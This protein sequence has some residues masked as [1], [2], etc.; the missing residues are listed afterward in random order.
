MALLSV[1]F[2]GI[3][4]F[5]VVGT[6][7]A[8]LVCLSA[9]TEPLSR[10]KGFWWACGICVVGFILRMW[11]EP[12]RF[13]VYCDEFDYVNVAGNI[14]LK[15]HL[16]T[17]VKG[18]F[19]APEVV[20]HAHRPG[21]Y[22]FLLAVLYTMGLDRISAGFLL[23]T[24]LGTASI[25]LI[26][27]VAWLFFRDHAVAAWSAASLAF[28]PVHIQYSTD[29]HTNVPAIFFLLLS[30]FFLAEYHDRGRKVLLW[31]GLL[32]GCFSAYIRPECGLFLVVGLVIWLGPLSVGN[33]ALQRQRFDIIFFVG[34][35]LLPL[36]VQLPQAITFESES[37]GR[38]FVSVHFFLLHVGSN[39]RYLFLSSN[40]GILTGVLFLTGAVIG[41]RRKEPAV[42]WLLLWAVAGFILASSYFAGSFF[43]HSLERHILLF[44]PPFVWLA[45]LGMGWLCG[46]AGRG[47]VYLSGVFVFFLVLSVAGRVV[48]H[49][50]WTDMKHRAEIRGV[51]FSDDIVLMKKVGPLIPEDAYVVHYCPSFIMTMSPSKALGTPLFLKD[52]MPQRIVLFKG[53]QWYTDPSV[54]RYLEEAVA[55]N[56]TCEQLTKAPVL[57]AGVVF[58][59]DLC[60]RKPFGRIGPSVRK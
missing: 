48:D 45:G 35:L 17:T 53:Y 14:L 8:G 46:K 25:A 33:R 40:P 13:I 7:V 27:R 52:D 28:L 5:G 18:G 21:A 37:A 59:A 39:L 3:L 44:M 11:I 16:A 24:V 15:G 2:L 30:L 51:T 20:A 26:Y 29:A 38:S 1:I 4:F 19:L 12:H 23:N 47:S 42:T 50:A 56:Y 6:S 58:S 49:L 32:A 43:D 54:R 55:A 10:N 34:C 60:Q 57:D 31:A 9:G 36:L 22:S 41:L